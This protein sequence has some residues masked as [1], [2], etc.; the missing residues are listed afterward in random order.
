MMEFPARDPLLQ[1]VFELLHRLTVCETV[2]PVHVMAMQAKNLIV[3][4]VDVHEQARTE[5][6]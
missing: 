1:E 2:E 4:Y 3:R 5:V 6:T